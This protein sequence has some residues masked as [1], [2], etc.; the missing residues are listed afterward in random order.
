MAEPEAQVSR[1][2]GAGEPAGSFAAHKQCVTA[3]AALRGGANEAQRLA[4]TAG[5]PSSAD[6]AGRS[7][8]STIH[9]PGSASLCRFYGILAEKHPHC[10]CVFF[11]GLKTLM[12]HSKARPPVSHLLLWQHVWS[13]AC[14]LW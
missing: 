7:T 10:S 4:L 9:T 14:G 12:K 2:A 13:G 8:M 6:V 11:C 3:V 1:L 5:G